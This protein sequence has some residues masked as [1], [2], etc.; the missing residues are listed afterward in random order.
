MPRRSSLRTLA[1][2]ALALALL[3]A[4]PCAALAGSD[5]CCGMSANCGDAS[6]SPCAQLA[7]AP[8][9]EANGSPLEGTVAL[10]RLELAQ[11]GFTSPRIDV[12][13]ELRPV[14]FAHVPPAARSADVAL[15]SV[16]LRL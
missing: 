9:C 13:A 8:C 3:S 16:I 1:L 7:A 14:F 10:A 4:L 2:L 5:S 12:P 15:R 11:H 6:E